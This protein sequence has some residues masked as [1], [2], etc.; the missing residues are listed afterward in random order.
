VGDGVSGTTKMQ[1]GLTLITVTLVIGINLAGHNLQWWLSVVIALS[2]AA[3]GSVGRLI[4]RNDF[5]EQIRRISVTKLPP[6]QGFGA[7]NGRYL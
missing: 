5:R 3:A 6:A 7:D 2:I 1:L 4:G